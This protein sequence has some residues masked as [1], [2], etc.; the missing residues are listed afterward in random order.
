MARILNRCEIKLCSAC[1][2]VVE[3]NGMDRACPCGCR[4]LLDIHFPRTKLSK[5][6]EDFIPFKETKKKDN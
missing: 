3:I 6:P 1:G 2:N 4:E 5:Q